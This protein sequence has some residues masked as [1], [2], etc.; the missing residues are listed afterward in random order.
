MRRLSLVV[1]VLALVLAGCGGGATKPASEMPA[2]VMNN[3]YI[4]GGLGAVGVAPPSPGGIQHQ[5]TQAIANAR[6]ELARQIKLKVKNMVDRFYQEA[7]NYMNEEANL[8]A[9][10][11]TREVSRQVA[12]ATLQGSQ[13]RAMWTDPN[14]KDLYVWVVISSDAIAAA[15]KQAMKEQAKKEAL[16]VEFKAEQ[17]EALLDK[18]VSEEFPE[19]KGE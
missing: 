15:A 19:E 16:Y 3:G 9:M 18:V 11:F 6:D 2:W 13:V 14:T 1:V 12:N 17:A 7:K 5:R 10:E 8:Q 4:E